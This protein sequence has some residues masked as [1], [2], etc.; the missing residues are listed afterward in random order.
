MLHNEEYNT[1]VTRIDTY[2]SS[3]H[4]GDLHLFN[5]GKVECRICTMNNG[6]ICSH[7]TNNHCSKRDNNNYPT[8]YHKKIIRAA[9]RL[10][11]KFAVA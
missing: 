6:G 4:N 10:Y 7:C 9:D 8:T 2:V 11:A 3:R 1:N 5:Q